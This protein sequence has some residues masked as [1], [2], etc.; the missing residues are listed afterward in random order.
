MRR[1]FGLAVLYLLVSSS[2]IA[3]TPGPPQLE[4]LEACRADLTDAGRRSSFQGTAVLQVESGPNGA[5]VAVED[6]RVPE[7]FPAFVQMAEVKACVKRWKFSGAGATVVTFTAGTT[8]ETLR[9]WRI[10]VGSDGPGLV[11]VLPRG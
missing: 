4:S 2:T 5:V 8:G 6:L 1:A 9:A 7:V 10:S 11:L 3:Q